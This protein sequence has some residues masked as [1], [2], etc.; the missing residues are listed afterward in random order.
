[1]EH[2]NSF[3][4]KGWGFPCMFSKDY[5]QVIMVS[6][7]EDIR[8]SLIILLHTNPGERIMQP[9]YGCGIKRMVFERIGETEKK[10]L[11]DLIDRA[12]LFYEPR[13][14]L[15]TVDIITGRH[16]SEAM[17]DIKIEYTV[18]TTNTRSNLVF[19][20]YLREGTNVTV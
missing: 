11:H 20:F 12:I 4:G 15:H 19:P 2:D 17:V 9:E 7:E 13:I 18:R 14:T 1:M 16:D 8:D 6:E 3:L 10:L 5:R